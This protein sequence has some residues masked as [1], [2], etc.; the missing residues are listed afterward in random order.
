MSDWQTYRPRTV[1]ATRSFRLRPNWRLVA[2][3]AQGIEGPAI[4]VLSAPDAVI[5]VDPSHTCQPARSAAWRSSWRKT[6][7]LGRAMEAFSPIMET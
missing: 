4:A 3:P 7:L 1:N 2:S 6:K 5:F